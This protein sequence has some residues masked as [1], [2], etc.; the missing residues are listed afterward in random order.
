MRECS[1]SK[2]RREF[3]RVQFFLYR[4]ALLL[5]LFDV[6][7]VKISLGSQNISDEGVISIA[8]SLS[9]SITKFH[10]LELT[11]LG[12]GFGGKSEIAKKIADLTSCF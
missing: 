4:V 6:L 3:E 8:K 9:D 12:L 5:F 1:S 11:K 7:I 10:N 2:F